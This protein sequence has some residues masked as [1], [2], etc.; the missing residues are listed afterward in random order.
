MD[1]LL[2]DLR[3]ALRALRRSPG[4]TVVTVLTL[5]LGIGANTAIFSV[6]NAVLLRPLPYGA[7]DR[8]VMVWERKSGGP[9]DRNVVS[10]ANYLDWKDRSSSFEGLAAFTWSGTTLLGDIPERVQGR[11]VT[12]DFFSVL[13]V[14]PAL[15]RTFTD[16]EARKGQGRVLILSDGLWRRRFGADPTLVGQSIAVAGGTATVLGIMPRSF[17]PLPWGQEEY[18]EPL[19]LGADDHLRRGRYAQVIGRL[20]PG[21]TLA[22]AEAEM[23]GIAGA[24]AQEYVEFNTGWGA[25]LVPLSEQVSGS[26]R[27][28]LLVVLGAVSLVLL[29]ACANVAN[30]MLGRAASRRRELAVRSA[31]GAPRWRL[32]RQWFTEGVLLACAG[33]A[34][35]VLLAVWGVDLLVAAGPTGIPRL[36]ELSVDGRV[37]AVSVLVSLL[38][39]VLFSL[40][41][42]WGGVARPSATGLREGARTTAGTGARRFRG[43]LVI[44]QVALALVLLFGAGLLVRSLQRLTAVDTGFDP[45]NLLTAQLDLPLASYP[46][47]A[48]QDAFFRRLLER[49]RATPGIE[50]AGLVTYVPFM[51]A[52][53]ATG[54]TVVGRPRPSAGEEPVADIRV[55]DPGYFDAMKIPLRLGRGP[56]AADG[57]GAPPVVVINET[58]AR[59]LWPGSDPIG[60]RVQVSWW[61]EQALPE[62]IGVVG[63]VRRTSLDE[64]LRPM[65]YYPMGQSPTGGGMMLVARTR[66]DATASTTAAIRQALRELDPVLPISDVATM[67]NRLAATMTDRRYPMI[68][69]G[70]FAGVALALAAIGLYGVLA[71]AVGERTRELGVRMALG[72]RPVDIVGMVLRGGLSLTLA[73]LGLGAVTAAIVSRVLGHLLYQVPATDPATFGAVST[74]LVIVA[75]VACLVPARRAARTDPIVVLRAE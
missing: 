28:A 53:A 64:D 19:T 21:V 33:G 62:V 52:G 48:R 57:A 27:L 25:N 17:Q 41:G 12:P 50:A 39:G 45:R 73:G 66:G 10:P 61:N 15:G 56:T 47:D 1:T 22:A 16:E 9:T 68:L 7:P 40:P 26:S 43:A 24:L 18:W 30:L 5:A 70:L 63:D 34:L 67:Y 20:K 37:L 29:I 74:L 6:V 60:Q 31:L 42:L 35:G 4:F 51:G 49:L 75:G 3:Y 2:Q 55:V 38:A 36:A 32:T 13:A 46:D 44:G 23:A 59:Q 14:A 58:M 11:K 72:A 71:F 69:L 65:I 8:L 54:F